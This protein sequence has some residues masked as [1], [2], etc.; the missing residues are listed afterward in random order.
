M[1]IF[2]HYIH[3]FN[4]RSTDLDGNLVKSEKLNAISNLAKDE[5]W[6]LK[7]INIDYGN[8]DSIKSTIERL[9][10]EVELNDDVHIYLGTSLGGL[11]AYTVAHS[12]P[13]HGPSLIMLN[14]AVFSDDNSLRNV[15]GKTLKNYVTGKDSYIDPQAVDHLNMLKDKLVNRERVYGTSVSTL[16]ALDMG[17]ELLD[18]KRTRELFDRNAHIVTFEGG[19]HRFDHIHELLEDIVSISITV[20]V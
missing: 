5:G 15:A 19:S 8:V 20:P 18:S 2:L 14:P 10:E 12:I 3:G 1:A 11:I 16:L 9:I 13:M 6:Q 4:S 7:P 17:D